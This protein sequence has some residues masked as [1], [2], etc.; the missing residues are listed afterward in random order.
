M[1]PPKVVLAAVDF[2]DPSRIALACAAR[3]AKHC[4]AQLH[5]LHVED[6]LLA[7]AAQSSGVDLAR[8]TREELGRFMQSASPAGEW[9]P[10]H[11]VIAGSSV[12]V[13][14]HIAE[15]ESA[16]VI[17]IG[18]R[19]MSGIEKA[20][21]GSTTEGVLRKADTSV[22]VVP[23]R[24]S[25]PRPDLDDL[26]GTGPIVVGLELTPAAIEAARD[27][28]ALAALLGTS[29]EIRHV[30]PPMPVLSRWSAHADAALRKRMDTARAEVESALHYLVNVTPARVDIETGSV[31]ERLAEA[32][33][34]A[35]GRHPLLVLGRRTADERG[36]TPGATAYR[37][38]SRV[39]AP[40]LMCLPEA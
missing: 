13:I 19:G 7:A 39:D 4:R 29:I 34:P 40:V 31:A 12:D 11:H 3:L 8:E 1:F 32:V 22:L 28:A 16:D 35:A 38:L 33:K 24:W 2:S 9:A 15:R 10:A 30:V 18:A 37:V 36:G 5:V 23:E 14:C 6:P 25:P 20:V 26:T 21:F 17:V 27:A